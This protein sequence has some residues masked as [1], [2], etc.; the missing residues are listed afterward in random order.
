VPAIQIP[1]MTLAAASAVGIAAAQTRGGAGAFTLTS[2]TVT[3]DVARRVLF[4]CVGNESSRVFT[5]TGTDRY[6][7]TQS[8]AVS[9][10]NAT[11]TFTQQDFLTIT[12]VTSD[13]ATAGNVSIGT[14]EIASSAPLILDQFVAPSQ[15]G[16]TGRVLSGAVQYRFEITNE[17]YSP[18]WDLAANVP[19]WWSP[20]GVSN[21]NQSFAGMVET[22]ASMIRLTRIA[23]TGTVTAW[24]NQS[25]GFSK[26]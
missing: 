10:V 22:P 13:A 19:F 6:G 18:N 23:G 25:Q 15:I 14:N 1:T 5:V 3:L 26:V 11:T 24:I 9:G 21:L 17:D 12:S 16:I 20:D 4:T 8:E 2:S 7:R